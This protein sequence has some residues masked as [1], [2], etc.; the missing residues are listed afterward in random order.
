MPDA[1]RL[2]GLQNLCNILSLRAFVGRV[3]RLRRIRHEQSTLCQQ[4]PLSLYIPKNTSRHRQLSGAGL[5][6]IFA[7]HCRVHYG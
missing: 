2:S 1:L 4:S 6:W 7:T 5:P 3:R